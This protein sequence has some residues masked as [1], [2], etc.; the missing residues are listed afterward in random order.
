[1][2]H[3]TKPI[4]YSVYRDVFTGLWHSILLGGEFANCHGQGRTE[5]EAFRSLKIRVYQLRRKQWLDITHFA[6]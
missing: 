6:E 1:M 5:D 4:P 2:T 3:L